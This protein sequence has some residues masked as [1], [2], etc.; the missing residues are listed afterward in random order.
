MR[1]LLDDVASSR[2]VVNDTVGEQ[3]QHGV[4]SVAFN[5]VHESQKFC[6]QRSEKRRSTETDLGQRHA[7]GFK[8][9]LNT[10]NVWVAAVAV[11]C[12][13]VI[14]LVFTKM[15]RNTAKSKDREHAIVIVGLND[16]AT[17]HDSHLILI[18]LLATG[19]MKR[20]RFRGVTVASSVVN[21]SNERD[22]PA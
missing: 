6:Q 1:E 13:A 9:T 11:H 8:D 16:T 14:R 15:A 4:S 7:V 20:V 2:H 10:G 22:L 12:E 5:R 19:E 18:H 17:V 21:S 3:Q